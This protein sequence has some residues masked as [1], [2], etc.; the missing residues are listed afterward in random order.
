MAD[1]RFATVAVVGA[2]T[3][4]NGIAQTF[5]SYGT[6][7]RLV[8]VNEAALEKGIATVEKSLGRF[9][10]K[11]KLTQAQADEIRGRIRPSTRLEDVGDAP[12]V[13]EAIVERADVKRE[14]FVTL[15]GVTPD[16]T[17]LATNTSSISITEIAAATSTLR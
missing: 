4:G 17:I 1:P 7:V 14:V 2:G 8:D 13:V 10:K 3:M 5:A 11:E 16:S 15:D 9:V 12:L 6:E